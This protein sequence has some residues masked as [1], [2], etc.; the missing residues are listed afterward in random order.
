MLRTMVSSSSTPPPAV[1]TTKNVSRRASC[2]RGAESP[3]L[4][5]AVLPH[6]RWYLVTQ[7][8]PLRML[9][10]VFG[11]TSDSPKILGP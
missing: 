7:A 11:F 9:V 1:R 2:P 10:S 4:R 8:R 5:T 6:T 3:Q